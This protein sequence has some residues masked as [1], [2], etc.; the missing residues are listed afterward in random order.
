MFYVVIYDPCIWD[1]INF[2]N[3]CIFIFVCQALRLY[4]R[5][6]CP[7]LTN[8]IIPELYTFWF[9]IWFILFLDVD[10]WSPEWRWGFFAPWI[11][12]VSYIIMLTNM[13]LS[14]SSGDFTTAPLLLHIIWNTNILGHSTT[15]VT[16]SL[17][18]M[19][20][21]EVHNA[22]VSSIQDLAKAF[23]SY[24]DEVLVQVET[25]LLSIC[26]KLIIHIEKNLGWCT[27]VWLSNATV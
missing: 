7:S 12:R 15:I 6:Q 2:E 26:Y 19:G 11:V 21:K 5:M 3:C 14:T 24:Q 22:I 18:L 27:A 13:I 17:C 8:L 1:C 20:G 16:C 10:S 23:S 9:W 4:S 25:Q